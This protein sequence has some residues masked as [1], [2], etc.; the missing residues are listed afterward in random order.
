MEKIVV[1]SGKELNELAEKN[2][3]DLSLDDKLWVIQRN[4]S[5]K[6]RNAVAELIEDFKKNN[7]PPS[8]E[9]IE[10]IYSSMLNSIIFS[11]KIANF[12]A[13]LHGGDLNH[14]YLAK[15]I[16]KQVKI[17]FNNDKELDDDIKELLI[18]YLT[19]Q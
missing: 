12:Y 6:L 10:T 7:I 5:L 19:M 11:V 4:A 2:I 16:L 15:N 3:N 9:I 18:R 17:A 1:K 8:L 14:N 13:D